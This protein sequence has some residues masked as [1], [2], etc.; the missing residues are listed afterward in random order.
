MVVRC[1]IVWLAHASLSQKMRFPKVQSVFK[2]DHFLETIEMK[3]LKRNL[4]LKITILHL[5]SDPMIFKEGDQSL[6]EYRTTSS[7]GP[8]LWTNLHNIQRRQSTLHKYSQ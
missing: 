5:L 2:L 3:S 1:K 6:E 8:G 7:D 4:A